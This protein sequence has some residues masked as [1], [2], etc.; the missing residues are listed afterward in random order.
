MIWPAV[1]RWSLRGFTRWTWSK[2]KSVQ[3]GRNLHCRLIINEAKSHTHTHIKMWA[4]GQKKFLTEKSPPGA[5]LE[6]R[7]NT[8]EQKRVGGR[9]VGVT[10]LA[11]SVIPV[12]SRASRA[13]GGGLTAWLFVFFLFSSLL[14][15]NSR[16]TD[17]FISPGE[18]EWF[19]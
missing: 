17:G 2:L 14:V 7:C 1:L 12:W 5:E 19:W 8:P 11:S 16:K 9:E 3:G 4:W 15:Q 13:E 10:L 18:V 6:P